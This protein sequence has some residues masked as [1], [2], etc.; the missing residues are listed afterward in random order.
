MTRE[1]Y[2][3]KDQELNTKWWESW[4]ANGQD[5]ET[6]VALRA[7]LNANRQAAIAAYAKPE[8]PDCEYCKVVSVFGGPSH[9][10]SD[11]CRSGRRP[12]CTCDTCF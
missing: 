12:H 6:T 3:I 10:A 5:H 2:R 8:V 1:E 7:E 9:F 4:R 11:Y